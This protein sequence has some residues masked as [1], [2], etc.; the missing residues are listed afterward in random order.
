MRFTISQPHIS[1]H[2]ESLL[3][4]ARTV[5]LRSA[6][7][8]RNQILR[9]ATGACRVT[10]GRTTTRRFERSSTPSAGSSAAAIASSSMEPARRPG[11]RRAR[12]RRLL[13]KEHASHHPQAR[14]L[15]RP[16]HGRDGCRDRA[17]PSARARLRHV[18]SLHRR[19]PTQAL[20][21]VGTLDATR[22]LSY[23]TQSPESIPEEPGAS[24]LRSMAATSARTSVP[25]TGGSRSVAM[26][27]SC[28]SSPSL[29]CPS[30]SG[31][32]GRR[33]SS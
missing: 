15:G 9:R 11:G 23:W 14:F 17:E 33:P 21:E 16:R 8:R 20:E 26:A 5:I 24:V 6:I 1:C 2:P 31:S 29:T 13:R 30:W 19:C 28:Q 3:P 25:G 32:S 27:R 18:P 10:P 12:G 4:D 22:C 7:T